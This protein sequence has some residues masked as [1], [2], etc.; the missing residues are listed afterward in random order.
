MKKQGR[1]ADFDH[2]VGQKLPQ[3]LQ[4]LRKAKRVRLSDL[5]DGKLM[6]A[7]AAD[8]SPLKGSIQGL[9]ALFRGKRPYYVGISRHILR[10]LRQHG[11]GKSHFDASLAYRIARAKLEVSGTRSQRMKHKGFRAEF[12]KA[13]GVLN[14]ARVVIVP[15]DDDVTLYLF[16]VYAALK[17]RTAPLNSFRTH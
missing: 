8:G 14:S 2:I 15:I 9:Y 6:D 3:L 13:Q 10:R 1:L 4:T 12:D 11:R 7:R 16:E 5:L 17:L